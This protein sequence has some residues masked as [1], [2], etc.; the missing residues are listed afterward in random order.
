MT[1][2]LRKRAE[3]R[4]EKATEQGREQEGPAA[5]T[6]G[7]SDEAEEDRCPSHWD[8]EQVFSYI[9]SLPGDAVIFN[10]STFSIC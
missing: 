8:V 1:T 5:E 2:R 6:I 9:S 4:R 3:R 7:I 10:S